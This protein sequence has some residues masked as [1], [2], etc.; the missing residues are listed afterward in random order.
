ME[1]DKEEDRKEAEK[2]KE[3]IGQEYEGDGI[4][5]LDGLRGLRASFGSHPSMRP[6][7]ALSREEPTGCWGRYRKLVRL[8]NNA[9]TQ[10]HRWARRFDSTGFNK[11]IFCVVL[12]D[13]LMQLF[14]SYS[15][16]V[17]VTQGKGP[18]AW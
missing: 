7:A 16:A 13:D 10:K 2:R 6:G 15:F 9:M 11:A 3:E 4:R 8:N 5:Q 18:G 17:L 14:L 1:E 12:L